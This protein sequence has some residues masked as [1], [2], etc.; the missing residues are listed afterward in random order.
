MQLLSL[1]IAGQLPEGNQPACRAGELAN[2]LHHLGRGH[3]DHKPQVLCNK[4]Q[5]QGDFLK[6]LTGL[7]QSSMWSSPRLRGRLHTLSLSL[8]SWRGKSSSASKRFHFCLQMKGSS[9]LFWS[10]TYNWHLLLR[11]KTRRRRSARPRRRLRLKGKLQVCLFFWKHIKELHFLKIVFDAFFTQGWTHKMVE[12]S[13]KKSMMRICCSSSLK[14]DVIDHIWKTM[15]PTESGRVK[16][17][18]DLNFV[19]LFHIL[20]FIYQSC[21]SLHVHWVIFILE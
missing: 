12:I 1:V 16:V 20:A 13:S 18:Y 14:S 7:M 8:T 15:S 6:L 4:Y 11:F 21:L 9:E 3:Q 10:H 17:D 2:I 19:I 5:F